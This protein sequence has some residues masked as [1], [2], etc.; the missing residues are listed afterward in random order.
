MPTTAQMLREHTP[1]LIEIIAEL[2]STDLDP[3]TPVGQAAP[4]LADSIT[5][6]AS[7][8]NV[9][10]ELAEEYPGTIA[11]LQQLKGAHG[12]ILE[13]QFVRNHGPLQIPGDANLA[14]SE[15][16]LHPRS[17]SEVLYFHALIG[18]YFS[19]S[20]REAA[21]KIYIPT[22]I[23]QLIPEPEGDEDEK[24]LDIEPARPPATEQILDTTDYL[25]SD[26]LSYLAVLLHH[27]W[28]LRDGKPHPEDIELLKERLLVMPDTDLLAVRLELLCHLAAEMGLVED[29]RTEAGRAVRTLHGN[30]VHRFLMLDRA[31]QRRA[32]W[33]TWFR[34]ATWSDLRHVPVLDCRNLERWGA[35]A[36]AVGTR[37]NFGQALAILPLTRWF[38]LPDV[39]DAIHRFNPDFQRTTGD[40]DSWYVWHREEKAFVGGFDKW[41]LVEGELARFLLEGPLLWLDA[42]R[43]ASS[44]GGPPILTLTRNGATWLGR[45]LEQLP[46]SARPRV[47]VHPDF[48]VEV[49]VAM[50]L[51][52]RFRVERF[53]NWVRTDQVYRYQINQRSLDRAFGAGLTATQIVEAL[54]AMTNDLPPAIANGIQRYE[55]RKASTGR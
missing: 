55:G 28:R 21:S 35:P 38:R 40:Y 52:A 30:N 11:A 9:L 7:V 24:G 33:D 46:V 23:L 43:L 1:K 32:L 37:G 42:V 39:V 49:P 16:W 41:H 53:A 15:A 25:L 44:R 3:D 12:E 5:S 4:I 36:H 34:S 22:D 50:D 2:R 27:A 18:R 45:D 13:Y 51:Q 47:T 10:E 19:G 6:P 8:A 14:E 31:A 54:R 48:R 29:G 26:L 20:G 17:V